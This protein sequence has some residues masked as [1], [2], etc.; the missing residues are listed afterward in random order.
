MCTCTCLVCVCCVWYVLCVVCGMR[1]VVCTKQAKTHPEIE[2]EVKG[3][4]AS[5]KA[6]LENAFCKLNL[7]N[8]FF[9]TINSLADIFCE[10][11][12]A[13]RQNI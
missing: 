7:K 10:R 5:A 6:L 3:S 8:E 13:H 4:V 12:E 11:I 2:E 9:Q 1:C